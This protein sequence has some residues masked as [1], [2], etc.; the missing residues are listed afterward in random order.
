MNNNPLI[1]V[2][3]I[4]NT[5][6]DNIKAL[7]A[8]KEIIEERDQQIALLLKDIDDVN[9]W[10]TTAYKL[11]TD[12]NIMTGQRDRARDTAQR[13][14]EAAMKHEDNMKSGEWCDCGC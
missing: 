5:L 11:Q 10:R 1:N 3:E 14:I 4:I 8:A 2:E 13:Y 12:L 6:Q 7:I 9:H